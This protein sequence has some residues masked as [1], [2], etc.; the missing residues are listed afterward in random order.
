M[1]PSP[2]STTAACLA[3]SY[4][5]PCRERRGLKDTSGNVIDIAEHSCHTVVAQR[6]ASIVESSQDAIV[7]K[8]LNGIITSWNKGAERLFGY[9]AEEAIGRS[10][11]ILIPENQIDEEPAILGRIRRGERVEPYE[12][13]RRR[14]DGTFVDILL[15]V[16]PIVNAAYL[17]ISPD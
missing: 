11:T 16:S 5:M 13:I 4:K 6:F 10:V 17:L 9:I 14:K 8:D 7:S 12:T 3:V 1:T 15:T 2:R